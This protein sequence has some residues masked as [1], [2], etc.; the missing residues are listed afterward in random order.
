M[1]VAAPRAILFIRPQAERKPTT[2]VATPSEGEIVGYSGQ[3]KRM[4]KRNDQATVFVA[5]HIHAAKKIV[6]RFE[7]QS[8]KTFV[9]LDVASQCLQFRGVKAVAEEQCFVEGTWIM[10]EPSVLVASE[11]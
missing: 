2:V 4:I 3:V 10:S 8:E 1:R 9:A 7:V 11:S 6:E 5:I